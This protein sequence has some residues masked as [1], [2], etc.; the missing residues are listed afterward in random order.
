MLSSCIYFINGIPVPTKRL[1]IDIGITVNDDLSSHSRIISKARQCTRTLLRGFLSRRIDIMRTAFITYI[2][3]LLKCNSVIWNPCR[4]YL[5]DSLENVQ[6][7][8]T[9]RVLALL[10]Y[11]TIRTTK[12][13]T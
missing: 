11:Y 2:R 10:Y 13:V 4:N 5:I 9:K 6:L 12:D 8:F 7:N 3:P 1:W